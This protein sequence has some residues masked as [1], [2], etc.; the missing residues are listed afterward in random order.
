[1]AD[2]ADLALQTDSD[3]SLIENKSNADDNLLVSD[4]DVGDISDKESSDPDA[5]SMSLAAQ[6]PRGR[7]LVEKSS[8][9][10]LILR[11][12]LQQTSACECQHEN[13]AFTHEIYVTAKTA[14]MPCTR[15]CTH[16]MQTRHL[17]C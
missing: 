4:S 14:E 11:G 10:I 16:A 13:N 8:R 3:E 7:R 5:P 1:M 9:Q 2:A 6:I 17:K 12:L 15:E